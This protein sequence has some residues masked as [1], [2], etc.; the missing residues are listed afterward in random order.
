MEDLKPM[1]LIFVN[2]LYIPWGYLVP[3][4][5]VQ[6]IPLE[7]SQGLCAHS[8]KRFRYLVLQVYF[9]ITHHRHRY[10]NPY[11]SPCNNTIIMLLRL[12]LLLVLLGHSYLWQLIFG[13]L[14]WRPRINTV[15]VHSITMTIVTCA[16][17]FKSTNHSP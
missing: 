11:P 17:Y 8:L 15:F 4:I 3:E 10:N 5:D 2:I 6:L 9:L 13:H 16:L 12:C 1:S 14:D 7:K